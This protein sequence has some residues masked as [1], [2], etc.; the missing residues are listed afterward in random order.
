M[1]KPFKHY[2]TLNNKKYFYTLS[3]TNK[4][5]VHVICPAANID[6]DFLR[7]DIADLLIDLPNLILAE[8]KYRADQD[9]IIR[10]RINAGDKR[11]I[12]LLATQNGFNSI[13][14]Y[15]RSLTGV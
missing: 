15:L 11:K 9:D 6:Q 5:A 4:D 7:E 10:F 3:K 1:N 2:L 8:K 12:A 13:S 14:G